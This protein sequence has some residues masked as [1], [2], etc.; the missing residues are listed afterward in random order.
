MALD[1]GLTCA[2][3]SEQRAP[4]AQKSMAFINSITDTLSKKM[5]CKV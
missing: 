4:N 3:D 2:G 1:E 5:E